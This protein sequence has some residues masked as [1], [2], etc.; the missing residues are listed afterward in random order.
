MN[1]DPAS[2]VN[3][4]ELST[5]YKETLEDLESRGPSLSKFTEEYKKLQS[6]LEKSHESENRLIGKTKELVADINVQVE[7]INRS[8]KEDEELQAL[9]RTTKD[10]IE[11][12]WNQ[13]AEVHDR[14]KAKREKIAKLD[15]DVAKLRMEVE[16]GS[17]WNESQER[18]M[19]QMW[20]KRDEMHSLIE[21]KTSTLE[22]LRLEII[23]LSQSVSEEIGSIAALGK[24]LSDLEQQIEMKR[25][26]TTRAEERKRRLDE[27]LKDLRASEEEQKEVLERKQKRIQEVSLKW[28]TSR[29]S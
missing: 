29:V 13:V 22:T 16:R 11:K 23:N 15:S 19:V 25:S 7:R 17:G 27:E 21:I 20:K 28:K 4:D 14:E 12:N 6:A 18:Q 2:A 9:K 10:R 3:F 5:S 24:E 1:E 26:E 8:Q